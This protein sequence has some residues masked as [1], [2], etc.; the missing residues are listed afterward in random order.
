M[1]FALTAHLNQDAKFSSGIHDLYLNFIKIAV[2]KVV[3]GVPTVVQWV[4]N[5]TNIHED[6]SSI[7]GLSQWVKD[8]AVAVSCGVCPRCGLDLVWL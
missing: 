1:Y 2:E 4:K 8:P 5:L 6:A 7:P 3:F